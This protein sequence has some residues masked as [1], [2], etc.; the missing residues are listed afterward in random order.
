MGEIKRQERRVPAV[1]Y[2]YKRLWLLAMREFPRPQSFTM[3]RHKDT[4]H[5]AL[6][7]KA[8]SGAHKTTDLQVEGGKHASFNH[9]S[10]L[11][12]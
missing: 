9:L 8:P 11:Q 3:V 4:H 2:K 12:G 10:R 5:C 7:R 6:A 1:L